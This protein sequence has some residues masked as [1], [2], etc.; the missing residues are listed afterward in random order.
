MDDWKIGRLEMALIEAGFQGDKLSVW[1]LQV[2]NVPP[3]SSL[4]QHR[5]IF[6]HGLFM[7]ESIENLHNVG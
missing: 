4:P 7:C 3:A 2:R 5:R 6:R 1:V